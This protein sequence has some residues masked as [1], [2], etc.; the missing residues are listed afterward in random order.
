MVEAEESSVYVSAYGRVERLS[1]DTVAL[2]TLHD[3][4]KKHFELTGDFRV[5]VQEDGQELRSDAQVL[6]AVERSRSLRVM[7]GDHAL[8]ELEQKMWQLRQMQLGFFQ[9]E[10][11]QLK[12]AQTSAKDE[13]QRLRN[14]LEMQSQMLGEMAKELRAERR[15]REECEQ[16]FTKQQNELR[17]ELRGDQRG[18]ETGEATLRKELQEVRQEVLRIYAASER[19]VSELQKAVGKEAKTRGKTIEALL[20]EWASWASSQQELR[21]ELSEVKALA[22]RHGANEK[23]DSPAIKRSDNDRQIGSGEC[24]ELME[25]T[26]S[27]HVRIQ[28]EVGAKA[29][30]ERLNNKLQSAMEELHEEVRMAATDAA[31]AVCRAEEAA[32]DAAAA[33]R[34]VDCLASDAEIDEWRGQRFTAQSMSAPPPPPLAQAACVAPPSAHSACTVDPYRPAQS[35]APPVVMGSASSIPLSRGRMSPLRGSHCSS[36][37]S[38]SSPA[39]HMGVSDPTASGPVPVLP[40]SQDASLTVAGLLGSGHAAQLP[41][42]KSLGDPRHLAHGISVAGNGGA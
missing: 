18:Q 28:L 42:R 21:A 14:A 36:P 17:D 37:P 8:A 12:H 32:I 15:A 3:C 38:Q 31:E 39:M 16:R 40:L 33:R 20:S 9:D 27:E 5:H 2:S 11:L 1:L 6:D 30:S 13:A 23:A 4:I 35:F 29:V 41:R 25:K 19:D 7:P 22:E 34:A 24:Q 10:L 26:I